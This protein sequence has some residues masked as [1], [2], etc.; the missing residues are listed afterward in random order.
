MIHDFPR[1]GSKPGELSPAYR[2]APFLLTNFVIQSSFRSLSVAGRRQAQAVALYATLVGALN[3][4]DTLAVTPEVVA[5]LILG[6]TF[7]SAG[8]LCWASDAQL[9][10]T[11]GIF[12]VGL[13]AFSLALVVWFATGNVLAPVGA[14]LGLGVLAAFPQT[15]GLAAV[16]AD[17]NLPWLLGPTLLVG[18]LALWL[19]G[20]A[21]P[22]RN[23]DNVCHAAASPPHCP[24]PAEMSAQDEARV[25]LLLDR[26]LQPVDAFEGFEWRDQFQTAAIRYQVNFM[27]YGLAMARQSHAPAATA[28]YAEAQRRLI[29]KVGDHRV[30]RYWQLESAWGN[31]RRD[32]DPIP[33][34]NIMYSGF[35]L[36]QMALGGETRLDLAKAGQ[37]W[38]R[39]D[40]DCIASGLARQY[41][42]A[43]Y[44]L[45]ACEPNWIYPLCN[46][47][48]MAGIKASDARLGTDRWEEM[49]EPFFSALDREATRKDGS[50]IAFRSSLT[51]IAPPAPG[52]IVMQAFPCLFLNVL[53]PQ[54]AQEL[55]KLVRRKLDSGSWQR[56]FWPVDTGNYG[57][58]RA[59]S[60]AATAAAAVEMGDQEVADE[61]LRRL[62]VECASQ[63][64]AGIAHRTRASLWAHALEVFARANRKDGLHDL[65]AHH[66]SHS[67]PHLLSAPYPDVQILRAACDAEGLGLVLGARAEGPEPGI[68]VGGLLPHRQ[69]ATGL[70][71]QRFATADNT[72]TIC[73]QLRD[74]GRV[75]LRVRPAF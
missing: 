19:R 33:H 42:A 72:G 62:D 39:Y 6:L 38:R 75:S 21:L 59:S 53:A 26:A 48:T 52:G 18:S 35:V 32:P 4:L 64:D 56:L 68:R 63:V 34:Q 54:R 45:L 13:I 8:F 22:Q 51:G 14:W 67:G 61:C 10:L 1:S 3:A 73:L 2:R 25:R 16:P 11:L 65:A 60:Y 44:G 46:L 27:A 7:P 70:S 17:T 36:L 74:R 15:V 37:V 69:Y 9:I 50:F 28:T 47:I 57:F 24:D 41:R 43:P 66:R 23:V 30:W 29:R 20:L 58:S 71:H 31:L 49:A 12:A 40:M 5:P 55:W